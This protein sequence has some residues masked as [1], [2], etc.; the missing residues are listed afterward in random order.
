M[1]TVTTKLGIKILSFLFLI[2]AFSGCDISDDNKCKQT[3][4]VEV[5]AVNGPTTAAVNEEITLTIGFKVL[6]SCGSFSSFLNEGTATAPII[7]VM[8][9]YDGCSCDKKSSIQSQ[10]YKF[11]ATATGT[12]ILKFS[13]N[14]G[15]AESSFITKTIIVS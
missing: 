12:Y 4:P 7:T 15:N 2:I 6:S 10:P 13:V 3:L 5:T 9:D 11:K 14:G 1:K 8:I